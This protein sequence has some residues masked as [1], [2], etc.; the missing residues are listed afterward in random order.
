MNRAKYDYNGKK[1][2]EYEVTQMQRAME[3]KIR[4][5]RREPIGYDVA[6]NE[7]LFDELKNEIKLDFNAAAVKLKDQEAKLKDLVAQTGFRNKTNRLQVAG[8]GRSISQKAV[9]ADK[10]LEKQ[11]QYDIMMADVKNACGIKGK[12]SIPP[13]RISVEYYSF[14]E[15][16]INKQ[17]AHNVTQEDAV[18]F[19]NLSVIS[20]E[21]WNGR[22][23][24][25]F[26]PK[27]AAYIDTENGVIRTAFNSDEYD[28]KVLLLMEELKKHGLL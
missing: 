23:V 26:S 15:K 5:T 24:S 6:L 16:H 4:E 19:I 7:N 27:G 3:R 2:T 17:R 8:F 13:K 1:Y 21:R 25:Y 12:Y 10:T 22:F 14:D 28:E 11:H 18:S 9:A 20:I